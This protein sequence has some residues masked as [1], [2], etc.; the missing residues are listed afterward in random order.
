MFGKVGR[1]GNFGNSGKTNF[2]NCGGVG[3]CLTERGIIFL[4]NAGWM[5]RPSCG[6]GLALEVST[7]DPTGFAGLGSS[8]G[9]VACGRLMLGSWGK[10]GSAAALVELKDP[11]RQN[12][13]IKG[14]CIIHRLAA[15]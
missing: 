4:G 9:G 3:A 13:N 8:I 2:G 10:R 5:V 1:V 12:N 15:V 14:A 6:K 7:T 11:I